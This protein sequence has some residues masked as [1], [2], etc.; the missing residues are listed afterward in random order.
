M[1]PTKS[2]DES[3][4]SGKQITEPKRR[5]SRRIAITVA[6]V[7]L[8]GSGLIVIN[9][10]FTFNIFPWTQSDDEENQPDV[11]GEVQSDGRSVRISVGTDASDRDECPQ[12]TV[13]QNYDYE[14]NGF[15]SAPYTL[16]CWE[17]DDGGE[18]LRTY[19]GPW[20]GTPERGCYSWVQGQTVYVVVNGV[21]S[22]ELR[23]TQPGDRSVRISVGTDASDR[24]ECPQN[25]VCQNYDYELNGF[26]SAPYTLECWERDDGGEW[27]RT[28]NGPWSGTPERGCYS[29]VQGQTVYVVVNG[30]KSNELRWPQPG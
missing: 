3:T 4:P 29:W 10:S 17:R 14:L 23:W 24:D 22:N 1:E 11:G 5:M 7:V 30:V 20:S 25:T 19:N 12:N 21:K 6:A 9:N 15:G 2:T 26:G 8:S 13:C 18:W 16:E 27:L 28:Y